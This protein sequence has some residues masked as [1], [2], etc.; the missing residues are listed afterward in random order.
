[1]K[2]LSESSPPVDGCRSPQSGYEP[3]TPGRAFSH[4]TSLRLA[5]PIEA[6]DRLSSHA[7][8]LVPQT[9][10]LPSA[11]EEQLV[12]LQSTAPSTPSVSLSNIGRKRSLV[13]PL[14]RSG[15]T[16]GYVSQ[17]QRIFQDAKASLQLDA[18][19]ASSPTGSIASRLP[20]IPA[21]MVGRHHCNTVGFNATN[22]RYSTVPQGLADADLDV[23]E[24][25]P[26]ESPGLPD[27]DLV[28]KHTRAV[29][30]EPISSGFTSPVAAEMN[31]AVMETT[32]SLP[33]LPIFSSTKSDQPTASPLASSGY[34]QD[35]ALVMTSTELEQPM[36]NMHISHVD[37][38]LNGVLQDS[39]NEQREKRIRSTD[40]KL[41]VSPA[42]DVVDIDMDN[43]K[44]PQEIILS[45][46]AKA[47]AESAKLKRDLLGIGV[48]TSG[49]KESV[50]P[51]P[52]SA[53]SALR[54]T[55]PTANLLSVPTVQ[56]T[57]SPDFP[58]GSPPP[59]P[60][61][62]VQL[63][64][65]LPFRRVDST[66]SPFPILK[67]K[68]PNPAVRGYYSPPPHQQ[69]ASPPQG[70][71]TSPPPHQQYSTLYSPPQ[72]H[73]TGPCASQHY[74]SI[75]QSTFHNKP[76]PPPP[77]APWSQQLIYLHGPPLHRTPSE[78]A[79]SPTADRPYY[80]FSTAAAA[81]SGSSA[82]PDSR[83][84]DA[85]RTDTLTPFEVPTTRFRKIGLGAT[86]QMKGATHRTAFAV[87]AARTARPAPSRAPTASGKRPPAANDPRM[88]LSRANTAGAR[89]YYAH[90]QRRPIGGPV[91]EEVTFRSS[92]PR[93]AGQFHAAPRRK[94]M[95]RSL[96]GVDGLSL[97]RQE[98]K[99]CHSENREGAELERGIHME[100]RVDEEGRF[101][102]GSPAQ[103]GVTTILRG[104]A[105]GDVDNEKS[106]VNAV[107][108]NQ[109]MLV[110]KS[111][112]T[113]KHHLET[114]PTPYQ[115]LPADQRG[116]EEEEVREL[117]PYVSPYRKGKGPKLR[118]EERRPSYWDSDILPTGVVITGQRGRR[119]GRRFGD[120]AE[121]RWKAN[122]E[123]MPGGEEKENWDPEPGLDGEKM[124]GD[125]HDGHGVERMEIGE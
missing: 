121:R 13:S 95:R 35:P 104:R 32:A 57:P 33:L 14:A 49:D 37:A 125:G 106:S 119:E 17:M 24:P 81:H 50:R 6:P 82:A 109:R 108:E 97:T 16:P 110:R 65:A 122:I 53:S 48:R 70:P 116:E 89:K 92:P 67:E 107:C 36:T 38:W 5:A 54:C 96:S 72:E 102:G 88:G 113:V 47:A 28:K 105:Q 9:A 101:V 34:R 39:P 21:K 40:D 87:P 29:A 60:V 12:A 4:A 111:A 123:E 2:V 90:T 85:Y 63:T 56:I 80:S 124:D 114:S 62:P 10:N 77:A 61:Q 76:P 68:S 58:H 27:H 51:E 1:M 3:A 75:E 73:H 55:T 7:F 120:Q 19:I 42:H 83:I 18:A 45:T 74:P 59:S 79:Y 64:P 86:A 44:L 43:S 46:P 22:W 8:S 100:L 41:R 91:P 71:Q 99:G 69:F 52:R 15:A 98:K 20:G 84:R 78:V 66:G 11:D 31:D 94:K 30:Q 23:R 112:S 117:S 25:F 103:D 118:D 115:K 26:V 93:P